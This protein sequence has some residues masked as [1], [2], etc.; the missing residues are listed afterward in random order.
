MSDVTVVEDIALDIA[1]SMG[2][3]SNGTVE[4]KVAQFIA[5]IAM[6]GFLVRPFHVNIVQRPVT[7]LRS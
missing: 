4:A 5:S 6:L 2:Q 3:A 1:E 7:L